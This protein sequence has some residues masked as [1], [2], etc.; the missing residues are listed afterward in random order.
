M[1]RA[2]TYEPKDALQDWY[3]F[4]SRWI[5]YL[6]EVSA[7]AQLP[8]VVLRVQAGNDSAATTKRIQHAN[9]AAFASD[10]VNTRDSTKTIARAKLAAALHDGGTTLLVTATGLAGLGLT[11]GEAYT[12]T[13]LDG[14]TKIANVRIRVLGA[15]T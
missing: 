1:L 11:A 14:A 9:A 15:L 5:A 7:T 12:G 8:L 3:F 6:P 4:A 2:G 13:V 10:F